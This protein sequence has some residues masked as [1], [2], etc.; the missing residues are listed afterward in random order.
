MKGFF[1]ASWAS[2][3]SR[4]VLQPHYHSISSLRMGA[5]M[6]CI[7]V[8]PVHFLGRDQC[9]YTGS[10]PTHTPSPAESTSP[11]L[12]KQVFRSQV[13]WSVW[14]AWVSG[15][16]KKSFFSGSQFPYLYN[17]KLEHGLYL[18]M[19]VG[20]RK[21]LKMEVFFFLLGGAWP[22]RPQPPKTLYIT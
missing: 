14:I 7:S 22:L 9:C 18:N 20:S 16:L 19:L 10:A 1:P 8:Y 13:V 21:D 4:S 15:Y 2:C 3:S 11:H 5:D 12:L 17:D 6:Y